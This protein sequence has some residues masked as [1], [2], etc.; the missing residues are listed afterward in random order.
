MSDFISLISARKESR[1]EPAKPALNPASFTARLI[2][3]STPSNFA[4]KLAI[5]RITSLLLGDW[6]WLAI[7]C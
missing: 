2:W 4:A 6:S 5:A 1:S 3:L 7:G